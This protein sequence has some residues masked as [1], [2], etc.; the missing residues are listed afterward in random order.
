MARHGA[1]AGCGRLREETHMNVNAN[2]VMSLA[3]AVSRF[4][5]DGAHRLF[6]QLAP[7][8]ANR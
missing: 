2:K 3:D 6:Y 4:I 7:M 5:P 1:A 8:F